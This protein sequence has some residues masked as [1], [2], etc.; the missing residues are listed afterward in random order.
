MCENVLNNFQTDLLQGNTGLGFAIGDGPS[1]RE[2]EQGICIKS[3]TAGGVA[4]KVR[5]AIPFLRY[6][7]QYLS[8][9]SLA[10]FL[11]TT[12]MSIR[13]LRLQLLYFFSLPE[14]AFEIWAYTKCY[15][16]GGSFSSEG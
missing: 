3:I 1:H 16:A 8:G 11:P 15:Q 2:G 6:H 13:L 10:A 4:E 12:K 7:L 14:P 9:S 5:G